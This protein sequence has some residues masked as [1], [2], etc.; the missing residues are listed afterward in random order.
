MKTYRVGDVIVLGHW[1]LHNKTA[2]QSAS[3]RPLRHRHPLE[4]VL[5]GQPGRHWAEDWKVL[6]GPDN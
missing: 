5:G 1:V 4:E 3:S 6:Q 2:Q